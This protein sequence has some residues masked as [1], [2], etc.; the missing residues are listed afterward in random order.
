[1]SKSVLFS[2]DTEAQKREFEEYAAAH[3]MNLSAFAKWACYTVRNKNR[4]G[5]HHPNEKRGAL[6]RPTPGAT[7]GVVS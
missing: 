7:F 6:V 4:K 3:G 1:M 2:F 5:S